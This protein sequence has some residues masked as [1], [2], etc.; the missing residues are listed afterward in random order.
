LGLESEA[1]KD[2]DIVARPFAAIIRFKIKKAAS[3][4]A[5]EPLL[6]RAHPFA[7]NASDEALTEPPRQA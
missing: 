4:A 3:A 1:A 5:L 7:V 2:A 6:I